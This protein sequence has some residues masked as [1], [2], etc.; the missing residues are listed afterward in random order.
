MAKQQCPAIVLTIYDG[1]AATPPSLPEP[2][3]IYVPRGI[4]AE[5]PYTAVNA[6][7]AP[8]DLTGWAV[9]MTARTDYTG[10][11]PAPISHQQNPSS[12]DAGVF[13]IGAADTEAMDV[14]RYRVSFE[15]TDP[16]GN[17]WQVRG[18][19]WFVVGEAEGRPGQ[20]V[21]TP[22]GYPP[23]GQGASIRWRGTYDPATQYA[24]LDAVAYDVGGATSAYICTA[25]TTGN[26]PTD[27]AFW[28]LMVSGSS[29]SFPDPSTLADGTVMVVRSN[30]WVS[31]KL[32]ASDIAPA[33]SVSAGFT[34][35]GLVETGVTVA[36]VTVT[37][38]YPNGAATSASFTDGTN[39]NTLTSPY[40]SST[41]NNAGPGY[42]RTTS[43]QTNFGLTAHQ[44][45]NSASA[46]ASIVWADRLYY[47]SAVPGTYN[48][49][50]IAALTGQAVASGFA[51][52]IAFPDC[53]GTKKTYYAIPS[54]YGDPT[55]FTKGGFPFPM[56]KVATGISVTNEHGVVI[57]YEL[58]ASVSI[59]NGAQTVVVS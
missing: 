2:D 21:T 43:G 26:L 34:G 37:A 44:G 24:P 41:L 46:S 6:L 30:L 16:S 17:R 48:A 52:T 31:G 10:V 39:T 5:V 25:T 12:S 53:A 35:T 32:T 22:I 47:D 59:L 33:F 20:D 11:D 7:G 45:S 55:S 36:S 8:F 4:D 54:S 19:S 18:P 28:D 56:T 15:A 57:S 58:W 50:F 29:G 9:L 38:S 49:A 27:T 51:R 13:P 40:T 23:L 1:S 3:A 42:T 14:Q